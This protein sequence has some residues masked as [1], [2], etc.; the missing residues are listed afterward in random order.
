MRSMVEG[1]R[2]PA[3]APPPP[4]WRPAVP[5]PASGREEREEEAPP[6]RKWGGGPRREAAWWRGRPAP[7]LTRQLPLD[8][9]YFGTYMAS[10]TNAFRE[11]ACRGAA[12][13]TNGEALGSLDA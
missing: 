11:M 10:F 5:L 12:G 7:P 9:S 1:V 13:R 2:C 6:H 8:T 3:L 4:G